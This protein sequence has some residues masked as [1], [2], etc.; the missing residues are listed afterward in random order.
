MPASNENGYWGRKAAVR[1]E[2]LKIKAVAD[3]DWFHSARLVR[4]FAMYLIELTIGRLADR[5]I[6]GS[7]NSSSL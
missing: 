4:C 6:D 3:A 2:Q 1:S 7:A 5:A